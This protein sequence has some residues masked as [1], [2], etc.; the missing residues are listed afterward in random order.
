MFGFRITYLLF[1]QPY[2]PQTPLCFNTPH[3]STDYHSCTYIWLWNAPIMDESSSVGMCHDACL[4]LVRHPLTLN[5]ASFFISNNYAFKT[6][7]LQSITK[8]TTYPIILTKAIFLPGVKVVS[9]QHSVLSLQYTAHST[10]HTLH[11]TYYTT[12]ST[13]HTVHSTQYTAYSTQHT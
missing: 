12:Y 2:L 13:Q 6:S 5:R 7:T 10:Q 1:Q 3:L 8:S 9:V 4:P 11:S